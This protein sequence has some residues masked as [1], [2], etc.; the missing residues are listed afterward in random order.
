MGMSY[1]SSSSYKNYD[2]ITSA[3]AVTSI[4]CIEENMSCVFQNL[5]Q[6]TGEISYSQNSGKK[7]CIDLFFSWLLNQVINSL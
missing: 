3:N 2:N 7:S 4:Q 6:M 5:L 1:I